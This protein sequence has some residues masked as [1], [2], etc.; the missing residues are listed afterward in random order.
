MPTLRQRLQVPWRPEMPPAP[1][2][3]VMGTSLTNAPA[4][5][6]AVPDVGED[7]QQVLPV[8]E[9]RPRL[10]LLTRTGAL[11][12]C[13]HCGRQIRVSD[14]LF[15]EP[16]LCPWCACGLVIIVGEDEEIPFDCPRCCAELQVTSRKAG[17][18]VRCPDCD[19]WIRVP[20]VPLLVKR[21]SI[22]APSSA[23]PVSAFVSRR[24]MFCGRNIRNPTSLCYKCQRLLGL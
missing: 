1:N 12:E 14:D 8:E 15:D 23:P 4:P 22:P 21:A 18:R 24:C 11:V 20:T 2:K 9:E 19:G 17:R 5:R 10:P 16:F 7:I 13:P 6:R 3:T